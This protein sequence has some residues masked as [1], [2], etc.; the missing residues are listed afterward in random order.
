MLEEEWDVRRDRTERF[1][2]ENAS[3]LHKI[4]VF[5][6]S[7]PILNVIIAGIQPRRLRKK[8]RG[9]PDLLLCPTTLP[10]ALTYI[11]RGVSFS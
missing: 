10:T 7:R 11:R 5:T 3:N 2:A 1:G 6:A 8:K 9:H 4:A